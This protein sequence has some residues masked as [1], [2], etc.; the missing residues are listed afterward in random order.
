MNK[1]DE[2]VRN[3]NARIF[4]KGKCYTFDTLEDHEEPINDKEIT[5]FI[6]KI[7]QLI[8]TIINYFS[9][10]VIFYN[11]HNKKIILKGFLILIIL[12]FLLIFFWFLAF[13]FQIRY[14]S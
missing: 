3:F 14:T 7:F 13:K 1:D 6:V 12:S 11:K 8:K 2:L 10:G 9:P 4:I 5:S